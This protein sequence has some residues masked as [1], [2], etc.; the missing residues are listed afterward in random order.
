MNLERIAPLASSSCVNWWFPFMHVMTAAHRKTTQRAYGLHTMRQ[1]QISDSDTHLL[2]LQR[3]QPHRQVLVA[4]GYHHN[5]VHGHTHTR[6]YTQKP[7]QHICSTVSWQKNENK[8]SCFSLLFVVHRI[9]PTLYRH[10]RPTN[11]SGLY[12]GDTLWYA[13][14]YCTWTMSQ[15][16]LLPVCEQWT[17]AKPTKWNDT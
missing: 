9:R 16:V 12:C 6:T 13:C 14:K 5:T 17:P 3:W 10:P 7:S 2:S 4:E 1:T 8:I 11:C 15:E